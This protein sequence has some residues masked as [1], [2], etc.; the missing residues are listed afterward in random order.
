MERFSVLLALCAGNSPV[1]GEFPAQGP[2]ARS[3]DVFFDLRLNKRL[4]KQSWGWSF[5]TPSRSLWRHCCEWRHM[6]FLASQTTATCFFLSKQL[7]QANQRDIKV[8]RYWPLVIATREFV[9]GICWSSQSASNA[10][11]MTFRSNSKF[12]ENFCHHLIKKTKKYVPHTHTHTNTHTYIYIYIY[13][14]IYIYTKIASLSS[15]SSRLNWWR[16]KPMYSFE[17]SSVSV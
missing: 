10:A 3:F 16:F 8:P 11:G 15:I 7:V 6:G 4:N 5:E 1:S 17:I 2:V 14:Y 13:L 12:D 9:S